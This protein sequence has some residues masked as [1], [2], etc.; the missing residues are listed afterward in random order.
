MIDA[1]VTKCI[2]IICAKVFVSKAAMPMEAN[3]FEVEANFF[4][5]IIEGHVSQ[6]QQDC[7][8]RYC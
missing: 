5:A 3:L 8:Q 7:L 4:P 1:A 6:E 2:D